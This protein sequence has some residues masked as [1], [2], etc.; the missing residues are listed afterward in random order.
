MAK[1][2]GGSRKLLWSMM[3]LLILSSSAAAVALYM[4]FNQQG[5]AAQSALN[6][7]VTPEQKA[8]IFLPIQP[9]TVNLADDE[10]GPR[11]LYTGLSLK[12]SDEA[13]QEILEQH[14]PQVRS[15]LLTLF[16]GKQASEL[17][18]PG[19]KQRLADQVVAALEAPM[20]ENQPELAINDV[21]FTEFIVQ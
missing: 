11:L 12:L 10:Y 4:V 5:G 21:L 1:S 19:S 15:R 7:Q 9:F 20:S 13:S 3:V 16:S 14:M 6:T 18:S 2:S 8:P 17:T